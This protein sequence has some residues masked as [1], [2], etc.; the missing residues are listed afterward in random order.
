MEEGRH[1]RNVSLAHGQVKRRISGSVQRIN[2]ELFTFKL[3]GKPINDFLLEKKHSKL[4][5]N[6]SSAHPDIGKTFEIT[7]HCH[8]IQL[9]NS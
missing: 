7:L 1:S 2:A 5:Q 4:V 9:L 8:K 3:V 6:T